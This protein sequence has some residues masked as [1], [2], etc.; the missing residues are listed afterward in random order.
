MCNF[1][2]C[3]HIHFTSMP[4][5]TVWWER[6]NCPGLEYAALYHKSDMCCLTCSA[7]IVCNYPLCAVCTVRH[8]MQLC[9]LYDMQRSTMCNMQG[10]LMQ[11]YSIACM[12]CRAVHD[13]RYAGECSMHWMAFN[14]IVCIV[15]YMHSSAR[16]AICRE[17]AVSMQC[18]MCNMQGYLMQEYAVHDMQCTMCDMQG[19]QYALNGI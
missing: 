17:Y 11:E 1:I 9:A 12:I 4:C 8:L 7:C 2:H 6:M 5:S 3:M 18:K 14:A 13:V 19:M 15:W 16:C 10:Y